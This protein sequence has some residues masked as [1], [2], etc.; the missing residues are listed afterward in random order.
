MSELLRIDARGLPAAPLDAA[1]AFHARIVPQARKAAGHDLVIVL[2]N[3][4]HTH[5]GWRQSAI[6]ALAR[7][8]APSRV[9]AVVGPAGRELDQ[10]CTFLA[11]APGVT[12][13]VLQTDG[14]S[15]DS[16]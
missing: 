6:E 5:L 13:Q 1:A 14:N 16:A 10:S 4:D 12:G 3:A 8:A 11:A 9:N 2:D 15:P 7:E